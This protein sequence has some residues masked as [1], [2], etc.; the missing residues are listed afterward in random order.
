MQ[1][2]GKD[3]SPKFY[4]YILWIPFFC[5]LLFLLIRCATTPVTGRK[6]LILVSP[7]QAM[8]LGIQSY[9]EILSKAQLS[10]DQEIVGMVR[11]VGQRI[12]QVTDREYPEVTKGYRWEFNVIEDEKTVNA[13]A[14]PGGKIA[15]YTGILKYTQDEAGV[16]TVMGHE[17]GHV[18]ARHGA[19]RMSQY[20]LAQVGAVGL[21]LAL[22]GQSPQ[23]IQAINA[24]YGIGV[25]VGILLPF[26]R[27]E[28]SEADHIGLILMAK[29]G[30]DPRAAIPFWER[31]AKAGG[32]RQPPAFLSTHP[33]T[34]QRIRQ[35]QE[36]LP[37]ALQ[38][39]KP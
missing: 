32:G 11:R 39:Y 27:L 14:L 34:G 9:R 1:Y 10:H 30:Y 37:E 38:Y 22:G 24:A 29:A 2:T 33:P 5:A 18:L 26:S 3:V 35:I 6:Q 8:A 17:I 13:F 15:F 23:T 36:W 4:T 25:N 21:S 16:A 28:E 12:A 20:L 7:A 31:M 19:E